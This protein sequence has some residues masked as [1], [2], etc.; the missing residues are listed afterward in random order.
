MIILLNRLCHG[1]GFCVVCSRK[2]GCPRWRQK[3]QTRICKLSYQ[4]S[5]G[6]VVSLIGHD[7]TDHETYRSYS[8]LTGNAVTSSDI[9]FVKRDC[10]STCTKT[11]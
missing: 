7:C 9:S 6:D 5:L 4:V 11:D 8:F 3:R 10:P 2:D 1:Y